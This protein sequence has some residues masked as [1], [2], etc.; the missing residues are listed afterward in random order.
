[1]ARPRKNRKPKRLNVADEPTNRE[2]VTRLL[3]DYIL[4]HGSDNAELILMNAE[5]RAIGRRQKMRRDVVAAL[6]AGV[7][8]GAGH[9]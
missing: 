6:N 7:D 9:V 4:C 8:I 3:A 2:Q 5:E 1:M